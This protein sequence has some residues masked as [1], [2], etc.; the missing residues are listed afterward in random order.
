MYRST[1]KFSSAFRQVFFRLDDR[2]QVL[3]EDQVQVQFLFVIDG[4]QETGFTLIEC[5]VEL[6]FNCE[7]IFIRFE[8]IDCL[9]RTVADVGRGYYRVMI[10]VSPGNFRS[11]P[12]LFK[13]FLHGSR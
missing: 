9:R 4:P 5:G 3:E 10:L 12:V 13:Q 8:K 11:Y 2:C 7:K 1:E 6:I